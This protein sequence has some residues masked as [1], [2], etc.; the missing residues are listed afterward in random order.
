MRIGVLTGGTIEDLDWAHRLG[1]RS[2]EWMRFH[3][4]PASPDRPDWTAFADR[5][6]AEAGKRDL[7][8]S[9]IGAYYQNPLDPN[10]TDFA[11][12]AF[13]R[14]IEVAGRLGVKTVAGFAGA[15]IETERNE[16]GGHV[17]YKPFENYWPQVLAF[18]EPLAR[19][20][21]DRGVRIAF[22]HCPQG[23]YPRPVMHYNILGQPAM[24]ERLFDATQCKNLGIQWD[25]SHLICQFI[26]P[27][28][29]VR[30]FGRKIF[31]VHAKDAF[32]SRPLLEAYGDRK[33]TR[34]NS[35]TIPL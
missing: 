15:V 13:R 33:S 27:V 9:A 6:A 32:I 4:G 10:Q 35:S 26:D 24:G 8:I 5:F 11:R 1:F 3:D 28:A 14:A 22:D 25:A 7:R 16:R 34:L 30:K 18:W 12:A 17:V 20:A 2:V 29:N 19:L 31:H 21:A 23:P